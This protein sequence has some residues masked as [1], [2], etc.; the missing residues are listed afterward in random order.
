MYLFICLFL[1]Q[2]AAEILLRSK[3]HY[4][5]REHKYT[6]KQEV[7]TLSPLPSSAKE[8][9]DRNSNIV[10]LYSKFEDYL[11]DSISVRL[12]F[13]GPYNSLAPSVGET[14]PKVS[15]QDLVNEKVLFNGTR[16]ERKKERT[17][18][19]ENQAKIRF[20]SR[21]PKLGGYGREG[22]RKRPGKAMKRQR[23]RSQSF[24]EAFPLAKNVRTY[25][26]LN[27]SSLLNLPGYIEPLPVGTSPLNG[28][29]DTVVSSESAIWKINQKMKT[30]GKKKHLAI[31]QLRGPTP[32]YLGMIL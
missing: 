2:N 28:K 10:E 1:F 18:D 12:C 32:F 17:E 31:N 3:Y 21:P 15:L 11:G 30:T 20:L 19:D 6:G 13:E 25:G 23:S 29:E 9:Q 16:F 14:D 27:L 7:N 4:F 8:N 24:K 22:L 26:K 5:Q